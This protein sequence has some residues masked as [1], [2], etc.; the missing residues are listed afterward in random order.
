MSKLLFICYFTPCQTLFSCVTGKL[1]WSQVLDPQF[2]LGLKK[3]PGSF[4]IESKFK[5]LPWENT[6]FYINLQDET[7]YLV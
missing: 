7:R 2:Y 3:S 4:T 1:N 5:P 6:Y